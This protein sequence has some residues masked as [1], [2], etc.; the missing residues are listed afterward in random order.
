M[1][2]FV[3]RQNDIESQGELTH[4]NWLSGINFIDSARL[5]DQTDIPA[6]L[7][8]PGRTTYYFLPLILGL[9]GLIWLIKKDL[10]LL[11]CA[12]VDKYYVRRIGRQ[13]GG[14]PWRGYDPL[15]AHSTFV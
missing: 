3:G 15:L 10:K 8:N 4:G 7:Q 12:I 11:P 14:G 13:P 6:S 1:W 5:G 2:N 9:I